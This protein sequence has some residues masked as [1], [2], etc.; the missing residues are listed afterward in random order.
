MK[1][2]TEARVRAIAKEEAEKEVMRKK[3]LSFMI[4]DM[5]CF[6]ENDS[7]L[8]QYIEKRLERFS[9][10]YGIELSYKLEYKFDNFGRCAIAHYLVKRGEEWIDINEW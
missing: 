4:Q 2:S 6:I 3:L 5:P 9:A 8:K 10:T 7:S 1:K